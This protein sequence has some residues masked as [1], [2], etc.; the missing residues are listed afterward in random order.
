MLNVLAVAT[1]W[2]SQ[3]GGVS[4]INRAVCRELARLGH[5]V[6]C[7]V[8]S[9]TPEE[10]DSA[11]A[12]QVTLVSPPSFPGLTA[13]EAL[14]QRAEI[15][16]NPTV[17]FGHGLHTGPAAKLQRDSFYLD[18]LRVHFV[19]VDF[20]AIEGHKDHVDYG[21]RADTKLSIEY[22]LEQT[23]DLLVAVG[24]RLY[25]MAK[26][27]LIGSNPPHAFE[28]VP[29][30][31]Q[32]SG[33]RTVPERQVVFV[34]GRMEDAQLK[35]LDIVARALGDLRK[36]DY[37]PSRLTLRVRGASDTDQENLTQKLKR[38]SGNADIAFDVRPFNTDK[39][40]RL[41]DFYESSLV[42]MPSREEGFGLAALDA[43]EQGTPL[44]VSGNS[45][46]ADL[47]RERFPEIAATLI[48]DTPSDLVSAAKNW[49]PKILNV[50][51]DKERWFELAGKI[52][53]QLA[54]ELSWSKSV[55]ALVEAIRS[56]P[57]R[58][59]KSWSPNLEKRNDAT[60]LNPNA[61]RVDSLSGRALQPTQID[62]YIP[63]PHESVPAPRRLSPGALI[64]SEDRINPHNIEAL[65]GIDRGAFIGLIG[66]FP[67][68]DAIC[69]LVH[70]EGR[71]W[72]ILRNNPTPPCLPTR[73]W[74]HLDPQRYMDGPLCY[75]DLWAAAINRDDPRVQYLQLSGE[76]NQL[77]L[78]LFLEMPADVGITASTTLLTKWC[79]SLTDIPGLP[80]VAVIAHWT[81][82]ARSELATIT[83][84]LRSAMSIQ[85]D[86]LWLEGE[87]QTAIQVTPT[88]V[89]SSADEE[90]IQAIH[91]SR[92]GKREIE[93]SNT[94]R[95]LLSPEV[96][97]VL[98]CAEGRI[99]ELDFVS[100]EGIRSFCQALLAGLDFTKALQL[101]NETLFSSDYWWLVTRLR[102]T[103]ERLKRIIGMDPAHRAVWGLCSAREWEELGANLRSDVL[104]ARQGR[105]LV[106]TE[107]AFKRTPC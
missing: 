44:L 64:E 61:I 39:E 13:H 97:V 42:V 29:G 65:W 12:D 36:A 81:N 25:R 77:I 100:S 71:L 84:H 82:I 74:I 31:E 103:R 32:T 21:R 43:I 53:T 47:L 48:I 66:G 20:T 19:H 23:A 41:R 58:T 91:S 78:G 52:Q 96:R 28:L 35:G 59:K 5:T 55:S 49:A 18:A 107:T 69:S 45:G 104:E 93:L 106:L 2:F 88:T 86:G 3:H 17:I 68:D 34:S 51:T 11:Q 6:V 26:D 95:A 27:H 105:K 72:Q 75:Q 102:P 46:F 15:Q 73:W 87:R 67:N 76:L 92:H 38:D 63:S 57:R 62:R 80:L 22:E 1:E 90:V 85:V 83:E 50:L 10:L 94:S 99:S 54:A 4:T 16:F 70:S 98:D 7:L 89:I 8:E 33:R 14:V 60:P 40:L 79:D 56:A 30:L 24:P 101:A 37:L 9:P